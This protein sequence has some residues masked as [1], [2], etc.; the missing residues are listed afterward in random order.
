MGFDQKDAAIALYRTW[1]DPDAAA[2]LLLS[3]KEGSEA[4][5]DSE[6]WNRNATQM[7]HEM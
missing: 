2:A 7:I 1:E 4:K 5:V 6:T 3:Q